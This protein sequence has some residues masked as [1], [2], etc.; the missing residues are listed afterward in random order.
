M[1]IGL[2]LQA[3][4]I[5]E[6]GRAVGQQALHVQRSERSDHGQARQV[7]AEPRGRLARAGMQG[8]DDGQMLG[9]SAQIADGGGQAGGAV[10]GRRAVQGGHGVG[11]GRQ[12]QAP[13]DALAR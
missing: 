13:E 8:Q 9:L 6:H 4:G 11:P 3:A 5:G 7:D 12:A 1:K 10:G 2:L